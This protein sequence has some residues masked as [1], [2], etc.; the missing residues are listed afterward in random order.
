LD[1]ELRTLRE[2]RRRRAAHERTPVARS[3]ELVLRPAFRLPA[4]SALG[5][6]R[7]L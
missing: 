7:R 6:R 3:G 1:V 2:F 5:G 4:G